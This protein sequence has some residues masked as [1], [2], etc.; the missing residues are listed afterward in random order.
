MDPAAYTVLYHAIDG[1][2]CLGIAMCVA[3]MWARTTL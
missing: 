3:F 2:T 1:C